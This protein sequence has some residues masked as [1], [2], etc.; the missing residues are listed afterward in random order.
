[1]TRRI[2]TLVFAILMLGDIAVAQQ[3]LQSQPGPTAPTAPGPSFKI[4]G[5]VKDAAGAAIVLAT[6]STASNLS[7]KTDPKGHYVL[8]GAHRSGVFIVRVTKAQYT[9]DPVTKSVASPTQGDVTGINFTG[10]KTP[11][12]K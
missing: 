5:D 11:P 1:M 7:A 4:E 10:T 8:K 12:K 9:F 2:L 3:Q 6:V